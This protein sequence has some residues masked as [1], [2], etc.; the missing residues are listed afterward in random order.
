MKRTKYV[1][2]LQWLLMNYHMTYPM[3]VLIFTNE[4]ICPFEVSIQLP[5]ENAF[6][7]HTYRIMRIRPAYTG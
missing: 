3:Y 7:I 1:V 6:N 2:K 4:V 5:S